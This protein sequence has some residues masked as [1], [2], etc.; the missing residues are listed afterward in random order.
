MPLR[1]ECSQY[2]GRDLLVLPY[3]GWGWSRPDLSGPDPEPNGNMGPEPFRL[4][5]EALVH[6]ADQLVGASGVVAEPGH[7]FDR[8]WCCFYL[9]STDEHD[10]T[11]KPGDS[12]IWISQKQLPVQPLPEKALYQWVTF[13]KSSPCWC[14]Y[15]MAAEGVKEM[16]ATYDIA[17][18][19]RKRL[20]AKR[21]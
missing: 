21:Q 13:D 18:E 1:K 16:Q 5:V 6:C 8:Y 10:F 19:A 20:A 7:R 2:V 11:T 14:G 12:M 3:Y 15:G 4:T 9:R 17:M